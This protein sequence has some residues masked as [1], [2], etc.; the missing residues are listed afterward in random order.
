MKKYP[1]N[2]QEKNR[3]HLATLVS[4]GITIILLLLLGQTRTITEANVILMGMACLIMLIFRT[5]FIELGI[6]RTKPN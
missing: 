5:I 6:R 1:V 3:R 2:R 4:L